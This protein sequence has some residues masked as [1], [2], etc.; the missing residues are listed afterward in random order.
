MKLFFRNLLKLVFAPV[1]ATLTLLYQPQFGWRDI[2]F[3]LSLSPGI[4]VAAVWDKLGR[5]DATYVVASATYWGVL[6]ILI[7]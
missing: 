2:F 1:L 5:Y 4:A 6:A 7:L 3:S